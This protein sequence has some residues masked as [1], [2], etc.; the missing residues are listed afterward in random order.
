ME[1]ESGNTAGSILMSFLSIVGSLLTGV[2]Q[3]VADYFNTKQVLE[4]K[5]VE[6]RMEYED[7]I[8]KRKIELVQAGL[9]ADMNWE[10]EF[11]RQA[12]TSWKDEYTLIVVSIP[13]VMAFIPGL[14]TYVLNGFK[15]FAETPIWYQAMVQVL[16][17]ATYG[18]RF[19]RRSQSDT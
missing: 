7:A 15:A 10:M 5:E 3:A 16:F 19:W 17:Y 13:L 4:A 14:D 1:T 6:R 2:P 12:S 9:T 8:H 11:A 18:I